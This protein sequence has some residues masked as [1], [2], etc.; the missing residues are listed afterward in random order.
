METNEQEILFSCIYSRA[1]YLRLERVGKSELFNDPLIGELFSLIK[2]FNKEVGVHPT[3]T[4]FFPFAQSKIIDG[5]KKER[6]TLLSREKFDPEIS[7]EDQ[8]EFRIFSWIEY[9]KLRSMQVGIER[10][11]VLLQGGNLEEAAK[12]MISA[13]KFSGDEDI[14][15]NFFEDEPSKRDK[16][17]GLIPLFIPEIDDTLIG[18][19]KGEL[20]L[21]MASTKGGKS[22]ALVNFGKAG[23]IW[24][25]NVVHYSLEVDRDELLDR[26]HSSVSGI[27]INDLP[28]YPGEV[29]KAKN[30]LK[31]LFK[32]SLL[33]KYYPTKTATVSDLRNHLERVRDEVFEPGL[34]IVDYANLIK[35]ETR[36]EQKR[37][38][39]EEIYEDLRGLAGEF[40]LP[41]WT[42]TQSTRAAV[43]REVQRETDVA[44][45]WG[46]SGV[47]DVMLTLN[48][49]EAEKEANEMRIFLALARSRARSGSIQVRVRTEFERMQLVCI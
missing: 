20:G 39:L 24:K 47:V 25:Q 26:Y 21:V 29:Q 9:F 23:M 35:P 22:T 33:V 37:F 48:Q 30:R 40:D 5:K 41:V 17:R 10:S 2:K 34:V 15:F 49:T 7:L 44:E 13:T 11:V 46:I 27:P 16:V 31:N 28:M 14:G 18:L 8:E 45:S 4:T 12:E 6:I 19:G 3:L 43:G 42:A 1:V 32:G 36:Y 38:Q